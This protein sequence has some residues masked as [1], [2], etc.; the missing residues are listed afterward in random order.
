M[1]GSDDERERLTCLLSE[2]SGLGSSQMKNQ[3]S[4]TNINRRKDRM[5]EALRESTEIREGV[6]MLANLQVNVLKGFGIKSFEVEDSTDEDS[7]DDD[8]DFEDIIG[9][10]FGHLS[11]T[12]CDE[13]SDDVNDVRCD[14]VRCDDV[15]DVR[16]DDVSDVRC[17]VN[18]VRNNGQQYDLYKEVNVNVPYMNPH[19][20]MDLLRELQYN[21]F[22]F[23]RVLESNLTLNDEQLNQLLLD[24]AGLIPMLNLADNEEKL[25]EQSRQAFLLRNRLVETIHH[26]N[27]EI[28]DT[29]SDTEITTDELAN[30]HNLLDE[31]GKMVIA[32]KTLSIRRK[33]RANANKIIAERR[34]L[35]RKVGKKTSG[36]L[37]KFPDIGKTMETYVKESS[38]GAD[39]WR[40]TGVLTFDGNVK[41]NIK[42]K[43]TYKRIQSHLQKTYNRKFSYGTVVQLCVAR[44]KRRI[45]SKRYRG[46]A[47][48]T[49]RRARKGFEVKYNPDHHWSCSFYQGLDILQYTDGRG[50]APLTTKTDYTNKYP[51]N[52]QTTSYNFTGSETT[53]EDP[54][55]ALPELNQNSG[56]LRIKNVIDCDSC[57]CT[58]V[59]LKKSS[60]TDMN[61]ECFIE[62]LI[63]KDNFLEDVVQVTMEINVVTRRVERLERSI[64]KISSDVDCSLV[65]PQNKEFDADTGP[66]VSKLTR[67]AVKD[68]RKTSEKEEKTCGAIKRK[69]T[70]SSRLINDVHGQNAE[71]DQC[72]VHI[73]ETATQHTKAKGNNHPLS[74]AG[75]AKDT[76]MKLLPLSVMEKTRRNA[77]IS[78]SYEQ[79]QLLREIMDFPE[80]SIHFTY[81][82][83]CPLYNTGFFSRAQLQQQAQEQQQEQQAEEQ[84][85]TAG[86]C[87]TPP[88]HQQ[89]EAQQQAEEQPRYP[90][91]C[92]E[93]SEI[94]DRESRN[95]DVVTSTRPVFSDRDFAIATNTPLTVTPTLNLPYAQ[96]R[97]LLDRVQGQSQYGTAGGGRT[98]P[99]HP[100]CQDQMPRQRSFTHWPATAHQAPARMVVYGLFYTG[101][102]DLVR[103]YHCGIGLMDWS[104][105]DEP[106]FEHIRHSPNC[107]F[108][109]QKILQRLR[110][111]MK[112]ADHKTTSCRALCLRP[113]INDMVQVAARQAQLEEEE[114]IRGLPDPDF[115]N[116]DVNELCICYAC[117]GEFQHWNRGD[118][119]WLVHTR[120]FPNCSIVREMLQAAAQQEQLE[121]EESVVVPGQANL[122]M[123]NTDPIERDAAKAVLEMGYSR[124]AVRLA[125]HEFNGRS[126]D[127]PSQRTLRFT[128]DELVKILAGRQERGE[129]IP[130][131]DTD[132]EEQDP[133]EEN[134]RLKGILNCFQCKENN[135]NIL[136]LPCTH[137]C[138]CEPCAENI[139]NCPVCG[140]KVEER[141]SF[142]NSD[143]SD[144]DLDSTAGYGNPVAPKRPRKDDGRSMRAQLQAKDDAIQLLEIKYDATI[145]EL[146]NF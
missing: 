88:R 141:E 26:D 75:R 110:G 9:D 42:P 35:K 128:A 68:E 39:A 137:H 17:D 89:Q 102:Q 19:Q 4:V 91:Q 30:I 20:L 2:A 24:F 23:A 14:D 48:I 54:G 76:L 33:A 70:R 134:K 114:S 37:K 15:S 29:D 85:G 120:R 66:L 50:S 21:W 140:R 101:Q 135:C 132:P 99:R 107:L 146:E 1:A 43:V 56:R 49:T 94:Q 144:H 133:I 72:I 16:V 77:N 11:D 22:A 46:V 113:S 81:I 131:D 31:N 108:L 139:T 52:L 87:R 78:S 25:I 73:N 80:K 98:T 117:G 93:G 6:E 111:T 105:G 60:T 123:Q 103:C 83:V 82:I 79:Q 104:D 3:Y 112:Q 119:P 100:Q 115:Q 36:I 143:D 62:D 125:I 44:N 27:E 126:T 138:L 40:R 53:N 136:L 34:F 45:S 145:R 5:N 109:R 18:D 61:M 130:D 95:Y 63:G 10:D 127:N 51:S 41:N 65:K 96:E 74:K 124:A 121:E 84:P 7:T 57:N 55:T 38:V 12:R 122:D 8:A 13:F 67:D 69:D 64:D 59:H 32:K 86:G 58:D 90:I 142:G 47:A 71:Q 116:T 92:T 129:P 28:G 106:L 97:D 118:N